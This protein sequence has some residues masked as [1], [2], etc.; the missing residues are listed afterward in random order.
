MSIQAISNPKHYQFDHLIQDKLET[1]LTNEN[2]H[3]KYPGYQNANVLEDPLQLYNIK[4]VENTERAKENPSEVIKLLRQEKSDLVLVIKQL[5][6]E[7]QVSR[8]FD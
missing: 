4:T 2:I 3:S 7:K 5:N 1:I 8:I 6:E